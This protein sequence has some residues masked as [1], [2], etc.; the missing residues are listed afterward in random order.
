MALFLNAQ[1]DGNAIRVISTLSSDTV[2]KIVLLNQWE[3]AILKFCPSAKVQKIKSNSVFDDDC[4]FFIINATNIPKLKK[5]FFKKIGLLICDELHLIMA[6]SLVNGLKYIR[7]RYLIGLSATPYR[8]DDLDSFIE[9]Y[10]G[11]YKIIRE[12]KR[13]HIVYVVK[14]GFSPVM[15]KTENGKL[16]WGNI[17]EQ[18]CDNKER[19]EIIVRIVE[20]FKDRN[21][22]ILTKRVLQGEYLYNRLMENDESVTKLLGTEQTFDRDARILIATS[23]KAGCG[24]DHPK[25]DA[26][27]L[28]SDLQSYYIQALGRIFRTKDTIPI[29]FDLVDNNHVMKSHFETREETYTKVGGKIK[30]LRI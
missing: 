10:F 16:N 6:E 14:T 30:N 22:L 11:S 17:I 15:A 28:A 26:L 9:L 7:P 27:I 3:E 13:E 5:D 1:I 4:D 21:I 12:M 23:Q 2:N 18:C 8:E 29:V 24:F 19:N 20:K 25:L